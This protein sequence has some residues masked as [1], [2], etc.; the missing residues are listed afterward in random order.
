MNRR[1]FVVLGT[2]SSNPYA[3]MA[4]MHMQI[5]VGL[6]RLGHEVYYFETTSAWPY[7]P[8]RNMRVCDSDYALPYLAKVLESFGLGDN[9]AYRRSYLDNEWFGPAASRGEDLLLHADAVFN[10]AGASRPA[11][12]NLKTGR[13]VYYGTDPVIHEVMYHAK[14]AETIAIVEEHHDI[15]TYGENI[16]TDHSPIPPLPR[17]RAQTRQPV[18]VDLWE[19]GPPSRPSFTTVGTGNKMAEKS[20]SKEKHT[21]GANIM[22][23]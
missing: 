15:V 21:S 12:D 1:V 19:T 10:I 17:L 7:D 3:G 2:L 5:A 18:L 14:D 13:L 22:S 6:K 16:G 4:W 20:N 8:V 11:L 9:W 23:S